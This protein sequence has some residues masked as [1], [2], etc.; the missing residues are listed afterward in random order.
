[1]STLLEKIAS[2]EAIDTAYEWLCKKRRHYHPNADVW[3]LRRWWHE[4]KPILQGQILSG[5]FQFRELRLIRGEEKSIEWW[6]SLDALVLKAMTIVLT[7]HLKPVLSTRCFHLAGNGGLKGAVREVAAHVE[8]H[9][10]VFRTDVKGYYASINHG[11]LMD[12]VGKYIQ[13]D[14]VLRLLWGYLR[15]YVSDGAEYLRSIP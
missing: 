8:E 10:F 7:E 6:S 1:M 11:I 13:D 9:P 14:A 12:I 5:K 15:R 3:Q 2:D 4:K